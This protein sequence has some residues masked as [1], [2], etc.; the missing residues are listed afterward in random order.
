VTLAIPLRG[1][2]EGMGSDQDT[3]YGQ[4]WTFAQ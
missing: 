4:S 3:I 2:L 1:A